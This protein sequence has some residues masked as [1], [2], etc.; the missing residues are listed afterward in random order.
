MQ[1]IPSELIF[2]N[3]SAVSLA[4]PKLCGKITSQRD[5]QSPGQAADH[6][7]RPIEARPTPRFDRPVVVMPKQ[8]RIQLGRE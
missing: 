3:G 2:P 4:Q 6:T 1:A 5:S 7:A 8:M